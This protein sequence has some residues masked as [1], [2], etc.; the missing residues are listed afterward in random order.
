LCQQGKVS[1]QAVELAEQAEKAVATSLVATPFVA[2][3]LAETTDFGF[4]LGDA[5][6]PPAIRNIPKGKVTS[7]AI[8]KR[9]P[10]RAR[11]QYQVDPALRVKKTIDH[12]WRRLVAARKSV[13][14]A[15][16]RL[17]RDAHPQ[18]SKQKQRNAVKKIKRI[19]G[20]ED[21]SVSYVIRRSERAVHNKAQNSASGQS[22]W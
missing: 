2:P 8:V 21:R 20:R 9:S 22:R 10:R 18:Q 17:I 15:F 13:H 11:P 19:S 16:A 5:S 1:Q 4:D 3:A 7:R 14:S 12:E 6:P